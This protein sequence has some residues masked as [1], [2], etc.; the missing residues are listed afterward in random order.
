MMDDDLT[1]QLSRAEA[2]VLFDFLSRSDEAENFVFEDQAE[3]RIVWLLQAQLER[4]LVEPPKANCAE[5]LRE[6]RSAVRKETD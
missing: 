5:L 6:A 1:L 4:T 3:Q 2:L